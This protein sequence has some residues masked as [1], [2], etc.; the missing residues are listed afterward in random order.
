MTGDVNIWSK[1]YS[2]KLVETKNKVL[3]INK[4][5]T[6]AQKQKKNQVS[7]IETKMEF[8]DRNAKEIHMQN[9]KKTL[10]SK[11]TDTCVEFLF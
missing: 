6:Y 11:K 8:M 2:Q 7:T 10:K 3:R 9:Q 5:E 1:Q 4:K